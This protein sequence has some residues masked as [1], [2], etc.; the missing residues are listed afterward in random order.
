MQVKAAGRPPVNELQPDE[1]RKMYRAS[2]GALQPEVPD[3]TELRDLSA[4]GPAGDI[5]LRLYRG[6]ETKPAPLPLLAF[7]HGGGCVIGDLDTHDYVCRNIAMSRNAASLLLITG[8]RPS[9]N[10]PPPLKT[11]PRR[12]NGSCRKRKAF[13][14]I[15]RVSRS[16]AIAPA[17]IYRQ[18]W[19][20]FRAMANYLRCASKCFFIPGQT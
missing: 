9:T 4:P 6:I 20:N 1:A 10:S 8:L 13:R 5:R 2:R 16:E 3:A 19:R 7:Y 17:A 18:T 15:R 11:P 12:C 14:S